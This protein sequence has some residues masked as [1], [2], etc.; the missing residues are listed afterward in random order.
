M[1]LTPL[2]ESIS[3][4]IQISKIKDSQMKFY[5]L[6]KPKNLTLSDPGETIVLLETKSKEKEIFLIKNLILNKTKNKT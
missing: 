1:K 6:K 2:A 4:I 5:F 3:M